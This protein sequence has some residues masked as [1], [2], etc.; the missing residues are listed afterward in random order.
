MKVLAIVGSPR[1][2]GN[3]NYLVDLALEE[4]AK[5]GVQTEKIILTQFNVNPC[6][7]HDDC[8]SFDSCMQKDDTNWILNKFRK[9]E[10][11]ILANPVYYYNVPTQMKAFIDRN[12]FI[13]KHVQKYA[14]K[15]VGIIIVAEQMGIE[16]TLHTLNQFTDEL[17][18]AKDKIFI[19][20][21]YANKK[22]DAKKNSCLATAAKQLGR[23]MVES[24]F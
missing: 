17:N 24:L 4:A 16:D 20:S 23:Q 13:Y 15:V 7:G 11:I 1:R 19:V 5:N 12:Y 21:A 22:G 8:A 6:I 9:S 3:T 10:G 2:K 18:V 14:I